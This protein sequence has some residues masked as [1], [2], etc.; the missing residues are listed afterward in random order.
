M[1]ISAT[2][3]NSLFRLL[4]SNRGQTALVGVLIITAIILL[5]VMSVSYSSRQELGISTQETTNRQATYLADS[6]LDEALVR[7]KRDDTYAGG[8]FSLFTGSCQISLAAQS[9]RRTISITA[10]QGDNVRRLEAV[11][12][13]EQQ[14]N[15]WRLE[16]ESW[17][18]LSN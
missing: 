15:E 10:R 7:L 2:P 1:L 6:C 16:L 14:G 17:R 4:R 5:L 3:L 12:K 11:A 9:D 8:N 13:M 18:E